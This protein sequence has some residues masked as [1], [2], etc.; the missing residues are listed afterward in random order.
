MKEYR[1][2]TGGRYIFNEDIENLQELALSVTE[3]FKGCGNFILS[4]CG[5]TV[6]QDDDEFTVSV[7]EGFAFI[8]NK[9]VKVAATSV[10]VAAINNIVIV[11]TSDEGPDIMY[12]DSST[13][14]QYDEYKSEVRININTGG[15]PVAPSVAAKRLFA[16]GSGSNFAFPNLRK[17]L[18]SIG[19][20][21]NGTN[22]QY[23]SEPEFTGNVTAKKLSLSGLELDS[24]YTEVEV[25]AAEEIVGEDSPYD[26]DGID[27][28]TLLLGIKINGS[29]IYG[30]FGDMLIMPRA[31]VGELHVID[32]NLKINN[33]SLPNYLEDYFLS[34]N[35]GTLN[36]NATIRLESSVHDDAQ[37]S[38]DIK[39]GEIELDGFDGTDKTKLTGGTVETNELKAYNIVADKLKYGAAN[40]E[41]I[42]VLTI[43]DFLYNYEHNKNIYIPG[44]TPTA[45]SKGFINI[46][47]NSLNG[48]NITVQNTTDEDGD[49]DSV[50]IGAASIRIKNDD[51]TAVIS[52]TQIDINDV[53]A[54][55]LI[56]KYTGGYVD[57]ATLISL[58]NAYRPA[59]AI[60]FTRLFLDS[61]STENSLNAVGEDYTV[62]PTGNFF[63]FSL[64]PTVLSVSKAYVQAGESVKYKVESVGNVIVPIVWVNL[65]NP[66]IVAIDNVI[67]GTLS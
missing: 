1:S 67:V 59:S 6:E 30:A 2:K 43:V 21:N 26:I 35:G 28:D 46:D 42:D 33:S 37:Y 9:I 41:K 66:A 64:N 20:A 29:P 47:T 61:G 22:N 17:W 13:D 56:D 44:L 25:E 34:L 5:I 31:L 55:T 24:R 50:K 38:T 10:T 65:D 14:A 63:I 27:E 4:G 3:M 49:Y 62:T 36:E 53:K 60:D 45:G 18:G 32:E 57:M 23:D 48:M 15:A 54:G 58:A 16:V 52:G 40:D 11:G 51:D 12:A 8:D 19:L 39:P 7:S